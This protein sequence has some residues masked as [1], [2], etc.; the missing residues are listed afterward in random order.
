MPQAAAA[1]LKQAVRGREAS[2]RWAGDRGGLWLR[3]GDETPSPRSK[4]PCGSS[5]ARGAASPAVL[6]NDLPTNDWAGLVKN[7]SGEESYL[8]EFP[9]TRA[10]F[11]PCGFFQRVTL[12]SSVTLGTSGSAAHWLSRQPPGLHMPKSLYR[13]DAPPAGTGENFGASR[14]GLGSLPYGPRRGIAAGRRAA[15]SNARVRRR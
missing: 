10:L 13:S 5:P 1:L 2:R 7:L 15:R 3:R 6:H 12:R 4:R 11:A 8:R 9:E 14:Q